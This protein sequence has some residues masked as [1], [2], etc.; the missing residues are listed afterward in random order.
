MNDICNIQ[1]Q[2]DVQLFR[3][4]TSRVDI[5]YSINTEVRFRNSRFPEQVKRK[6]QTYA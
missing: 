4:P 5:A 2:Y 1:T 6:E 3:N